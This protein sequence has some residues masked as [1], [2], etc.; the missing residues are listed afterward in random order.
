[1]T[2]KPSEPEAH[3]SGLKRQKRERTPEEQIPEVMEG[4]SPSKQ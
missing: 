2:Y 1:M 4:N 3:S